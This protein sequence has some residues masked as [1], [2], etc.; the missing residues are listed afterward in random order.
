VQAEQKTVNPAVFQASALFVAIFYGVLAVWTVGTVP[1]IWQKYQQGWFRGDWLFAAMFVFFYL[2][3]WFWALGL[4]YQIALDAEGGIRLK[5]IRRTLEISAK[6][7]NAIEGPRFSIGFGVVRMKL[8]R[9][10]AYL[11]CHR[12]DGN[13]GEILSEIRRSNPRIRTARI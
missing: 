9:E 11:F 4:C 13:L 8:H 10:S 3:T 6:Q 7:V 12:L 1:L 5:S 2:Y